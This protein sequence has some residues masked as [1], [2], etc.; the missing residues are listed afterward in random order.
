MR[1]EEQRYARESVKRAKEHQKLKDKQNAYQAVVDWG[2]YVLSLKKIHLESTNLIDYE[3]IKNTEMPIEPK[4]KYNNEDFAENKL[5]SFEP[6]FFDKLFGLI[7]KKTNR[8]KELLEL[9]K[10][11]DK[12]E[13]DANYIK[14]LDNFKDWEKLQEISKGVEKKQIEFYKKALEY[15]NPFSKIGEIGNQININLENDFI[16][17]DLTVN[18]L[19]V[20]PDYELKQTSTG[21]LSKTNMPKTRFNELYQQHVCSCL[22][23]VAKEVFAHLPYKYS[24]VNAITKI[25]NCQNGKIEEKIIMSVIFTEDI[26]Q[27]I[28]FGLTQPLD[29][30]Q[31]FAKNI[32]IDKI[33]GFSPVNRIEF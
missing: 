11:K 26:I 12:N 7:Q 19:D 14:Y 33:N 28:N 4:R 23:R 2:N 20:I 31:S 15:F 32:L 8:L 30:I 22:L 27:K 21:K 9:A 13:N 24:R 3:K 5:K 1:R 29:N 10:I 25:V 16:D 17:I 18:S 6:S